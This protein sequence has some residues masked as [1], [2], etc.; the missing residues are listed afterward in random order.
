FRMSSRV[1]T[2][3]PLFYVD[4]VMAAGTAFSLPVEH[5]ERALYVLAGAG[6]CGAGRTEPGRMLV[7]VPGASVMVHAES[8]ARLVLLGG[9]PLDGPRHIDWNFVS[10]SRARI[11]QAKRD[12]KEGRFPKAPGDDVESVPLPEWALTRTRPALPSGHSPPYSRR[13]RDRPR[14]SARGMRPPGGSL[15]TPPARPKLASA[16]RAPKVSALSTPQT[17]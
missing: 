2:P 7:F 15:T 11:E 14:G 9:A 6:D 16:V 8:P 4:V 13:L 17:S 1:K 3:S 12:W 5:A 10:S